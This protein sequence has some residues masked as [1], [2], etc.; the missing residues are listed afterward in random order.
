[1]SDLAIA[2]IIFACVFSG[3]LLGMLLRVALPE[4]HLDDRSKDVVRLGMGLVAT[5]AALVLGL[6]VA[7]AKSAYDSQKNELDQI[8]A[9]LVLLDS[10]LAQYGPEAQEARDGLRQAAAVG[11]ERLWPQDATQ[12]AASAAPG[13][14]VRGAGISL[15]GKIQEFSPQNDMQRRLQSAALQ[16]TE[17]LGQARWLLAAQGESVSVPMPFLVI[18][19]FWLAVLFVSFGLFAPP[20]AT[21]VATL[22]LCAQSVSAAIF[23]ILELAQ[24]FEGLIQIS[25]AP[26]RNALALLGQ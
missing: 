18:L 14:F 11:L 12:T 6:L 19:V 24:P 16:I 13:T 2:S 25:S 5:M 15:Y 3:A 17:E 20:N 22:F 21:V 10:V 8:S 23:L 7:S 1:M 26:L 4:H 9:S